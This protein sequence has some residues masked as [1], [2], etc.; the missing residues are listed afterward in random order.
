MVKILMDSRDIFEKVDKLREE[1]LMG[2]GSLSYK[3]K[4][5]KEALLKN[6]DITVKDLSE[7]FKELG[8]DVKDKVKR[9]ARIGIRL[10]DLEEVAQEE[11]ALELKRLEL[12]TEIYETAGELGQ[13]TLKTVNSLITEYKEKLKQERK[14]SLVQD[15]DFNK[16]VESLSTDLSHLISNL[17]KEFDERLDNKIKY[18]G[19]RPYYV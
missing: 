19:S 18:G 3:L 12:M 9:F 13:D 5:E 6:K 11:K 17:E 10:K 2:M 8:E 14:H 15:E 4:N 1:S 7:I 16:M